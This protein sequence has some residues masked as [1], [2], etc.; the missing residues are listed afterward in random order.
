ML[1]R[2]CAEF[3]KGSA[4]VLIDTSKLRQAQE[5]ATP[6]PS[7]QAVLRLSANVAVAGRVAL[8]SMALHAGGAASHA[9]ETVAVFTQ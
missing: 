3:V 5:P 8:V 2:A 9:Q 4:Q 6:D 7:I 1:T